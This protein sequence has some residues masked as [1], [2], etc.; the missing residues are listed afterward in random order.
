MAA[1]AAVIENYRATA[2]EIRARTLSYL[3][4]AWHQ[5]EID[6][7]DATV[8]RFGAQ[9]AVVTDA[10]QYRIAVATDVYLAQTQ[11][12]ATGTPTAPVGLAPETTST[13]SLR[14]V[15]SETVWARPGQT[16]WSELARH[17][18]VS[19]ALAQGRNRTH[20]LADTDLQL[21]H[22]HA[23]Q[24]VLKRR[25]LEWFQRVPRG[26]RSCELCLLASTQRYHVGDL[27]PIHTH[28][29]CAVAGIAG[30]TDPGHVIPAD[31]QDA[32]SA[33]IE[34]ATGS[35]DLT[36]EAYRRYVVVHE[37]GEIGPVL[38][39]RGQSFAGPSALP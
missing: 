32:V 31:Q 29:H 16:V 36:A 7:R 30:R 1:E 33:V 39:V 28:C 14:G 21:A 8:D 17:A 22:T 12:L 15:S 2:A 6:L 38:A 23:A 13:E 5:V 19:R 3:D 27:M 10:A 11:T 26:G 37:H 25:G 20:E 4:A 18:T 9:A 24:E 34:A 35:A